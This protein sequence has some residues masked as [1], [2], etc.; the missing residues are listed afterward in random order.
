MTD[1]DIA[2]LDAECAAADQAAALGRAAKFDALILPAYAGHLLRLPSETG[3]RYRRRK[4]I[5]SR[6]MDHQ[7]Q[8]SA[9]YLRE[10]RRMHY[11]GTLTK[12]EV[13]EM[14][15]LPPSPPPATWYD[16]HRKGFKP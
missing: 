7:Q 3:R 10:L 13:R 14:M 4:R 1:W 16:Q 5:R 6:P 15:A 12:D 11:D 9:A 2:T 8:L